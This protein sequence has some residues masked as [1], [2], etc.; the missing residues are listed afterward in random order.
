MNNLSNSLKKF[1]SNKNTVTILGVILAIVILYVGYNY[2]INQRVTL[3]RIP[4]A[5]QTIQPR[6]QIT[7]AMISYKDVPSSFLSGDIITDANE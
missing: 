4:Y 2:R 1:V 3:T 6:T 5:N 7:S